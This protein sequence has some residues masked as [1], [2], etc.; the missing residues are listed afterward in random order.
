[1]GEA[2]RKE[3]IALEHALRRIF[4]NDHLVEKMHSILATST[5]DEQRYLAAKRISADLSLVNPEKAAPLYAKTESII[6]DLYDQHHKRTKDRPDDPLFYDVPES[7]K[8][9]IDVARDTASGAAAQAVETSAKTAVGTGLLASGALLAS[10][11]V[12][13]ALAAGGSLFSLPNTK[14]D[15]MKPIP[16]KYMKKFIKR[17][18]RGY[19]LDKMIDVYRSKTAKNPSDYT[20]GMY[21]LTNNDLY[22]GRLPPA[23]LERIQSEFMDWKGAGKTFNWP[24]VSKKRKGD[25]ISDRSDLKIGRFST[26]DDQPLVSNQLN[27][28]P[29]PY[30]P[31]PPEPTG[32]P[33]GS[34]IISG[35]GGALA[36][37]AGG[38]LYG[39]VP[40]AAIGAV[41]GS[42][43]AQAATEDSYAM[44]KNK[45][46]QLLQGK[47]APAPAPPPTVE[48][49][50]NNVQDTDSARLTAMKRDAAR[51]ARQAER[52]RLAQEKKDRDDI[53][54]EYRISQTELPVIPRD[55]ALYGVPPTLSVEEASWAAM[56]QLVTRASIGLSGAAALT[57]LSAGGA[58][59]LLGGLAVGAAGLTLDAFNRRYAQ[60]YGS[61][62]YSARR[63]V[64]AGDGMFDSL[65]ANRNPILAVERGLNVLQSN[66]VG[67]RA[68]AS[69]VDAFT[70][71][72]SAMMNSQ[73]AGDQIE[74][75]NRG[76][77]NYMNELGPF[78]VPHA[79]M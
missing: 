51:Q 48:D 40:G 23:T 20:D 58:S 43:G 34:R 72:G 9:V 59:G 11:F 62:S 7:V 41:A 26:P 68:S 19:D 67:E 31:P 36:G 65:V 73:P 52:D 8:E 6:S 5:S 74:L 69:V 53:A 54:E 57:L 77:Q 27:P 1:M 42:W 60:D 13:G 4:T 49:P 44:T 33:T 30:D 47:T 39:G 10:K 37:A 78:V 3:A 29:G 16:T 70:R 46:Q 71:S 14:P 64:A 66:A 21:Q 38:L 75:V 17:V 32:A 25:T 79:R 24:R 22:R 63:G 28:T 45:G 61:S 35:V 50:R 55:E 12:S 56:Q 76:I 2:D 18:E 15:T